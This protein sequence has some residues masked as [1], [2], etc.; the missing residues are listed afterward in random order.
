MGGPDR[1]EVGIGAGMDKAIKVARDLAGLFLT[2]KQAAVGEAHNLGAAKSLAGIDN[3]NLPLFA[4]PPIQHQPNAAI[5]NID[6]LLRD[7]ER[8]ADNQM[9]LFLPLRNLY[10]KQPLIGEPITGW[11]S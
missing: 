4:L 10:P 5:H 6:L 2:D 9:L 8:S 1:G 7:D 3:L 11:Y